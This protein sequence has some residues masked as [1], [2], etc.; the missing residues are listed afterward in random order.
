MRSCAFLL[1]YELA[2]QSAVRQGTS[3]CFVS[4]VLNSIK[5]NDLLAVVAFTAAVR[6][7]AVAFGP[8]GFVF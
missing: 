6:Q 2:K 8:Q 7:Q 4:K 5:L 3:G 1:S